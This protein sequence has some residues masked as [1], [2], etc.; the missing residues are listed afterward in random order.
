M[1]SVE[2]T[3]QLSFNFG[4]EDG[5]LSGIGIPNVKACGRRFEPRRCEAGFSFWLIY[6]GRSWIPVRRQ[7]RFLGKG[8]LQC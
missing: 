6:C 7:P 3:L 5:G 2:T 8:Y 4:E 1:R